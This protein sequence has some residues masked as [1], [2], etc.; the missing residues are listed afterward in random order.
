MVQKPIAVGIKEAAQILGWSTDTLRRWANAGVLPPDAVELTPGGH[1]R[2]HV[3]VIQKW[4]QLRAQK[5]TSVSFYEKL[6]Q[7]SKRKE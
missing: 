4:A 6:H 5:I 2:F 3:E 1:R 7:R